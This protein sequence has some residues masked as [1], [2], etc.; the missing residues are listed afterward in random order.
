MFVLRSV[1]CLL[2]VYSLRCCDSWVVSTGAVDL[3]PGLPTSVHN[4]TQ[5]CSDNLHSYI[6]RNSWCCLLEE[7]RLYS[8]THSSLIWYVVCCSGRV[9]SLEAVNRASISVPRPGPQHDQRRLCLLHV[10]AAAGICYRHA[11]AL[12]QNWRR[13]FASSSASVLYRQRGPR[14]LFAH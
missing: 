4:T 11:V 2:W 5:N 14:A 9:L 7:K 8:L 13:R 10:L 1:I 6:H 3:L 12:L